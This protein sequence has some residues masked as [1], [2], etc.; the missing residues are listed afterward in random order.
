MYTPITKRAQ[1]SCSAGM[2]RAAAKQTSKKSGV[3]AT[4]REIDA[5]INRKIQTANVKPPVEEG[6]FDEFVEY[7]PGPFIKRGIESAKKAV[8]KVTGKTYGT[9]I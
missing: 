1:E 5:D 3:M 7:G 6:S 2:A 4:L 9:S 8:N